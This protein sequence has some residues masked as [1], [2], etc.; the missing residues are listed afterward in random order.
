M[1]SR[2][3]RRSVERS[4]GY[5]FLEG[6][7]LAR[8][9]EWLVYGGHRVVDRQKL[10]ELE[11]VHGGWSVCVVSSVDGGWCGRGKE[12][13]LWPG[14]FRLLSGRGTGPERFG[15]W[16]CSDSHV[17]LISLAAAG[18]SL[19]R[20][21]RAHNTV[22]NTTGASASRAVFLP[23]PFPLETTKPSCCARV[24]LLSFFSP[25]A[26]HEAWLRGTNGPCVPAANKARRQPIRAVATPRHA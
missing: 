6:R 9:G 15:R 18:L 3:G 8:R 13:K 16:L 1:R 25:G 5:I 17:N 12:R 24:L 10:G 4:V 21:P 22:Q 19:D 11:R 20:P 26:P 2:G 7:R 23:R 14:D